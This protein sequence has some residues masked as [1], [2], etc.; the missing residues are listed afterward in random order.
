[1]VLVVL[2][3]L[4]LLLT[5]VFA[6]TGKSP[7]YSGGLLQMLELLRE[8]RMHRGKLLLLPENARRHPLLDVFCCY[9]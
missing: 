5:E 1:M 9:R 7:G 4:L 6:A 2:L 8:A 3:L